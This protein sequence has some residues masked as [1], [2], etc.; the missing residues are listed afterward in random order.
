MRRSGIEAEDAS[1][2]TRT[3]K[4]NV[5]VR[6]EGNFGVLLCGNAVD[7]P[8]PGARNVEDDRVGEHLDGAA[9][10]LEAVGGGPALG[11]HREGTRIE[12]KIA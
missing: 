2:F 4:K 8:V 12:K 1:A 11:R 6:G 3:F 10:H 7:L 9:L 5:F